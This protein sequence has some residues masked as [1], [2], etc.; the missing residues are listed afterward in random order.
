MN[1]IHI[2]YFASL[3]DQTGCDRESVETEA[4][5]AEALYHELK[6]RHALKHELAELKVAINDSFAPMHSV[7]KDGDLIVYIPPVAGG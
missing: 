3:R 4:H 5:T 7:L 6:L 1:T 2:Q